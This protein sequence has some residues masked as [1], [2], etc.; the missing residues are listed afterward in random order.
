MDQ[1]HVLMMVI[2]IG[3]FIYWY[4]TS[5]H[6]QYVNNGANMNSA[7]TNNVVTNN[8]HNK[9]KNKH[10]RK[11]LTKNKKLD[12]VSIDS[13]DSSEGALLE[14]IEDK[15]KDTDSTFFD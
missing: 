11:I 15:N 10:K 13:L 2:I 5:Y 6:N 3:I 12:D 1:L 14:P 4:Q 8:K 9:K 7:S